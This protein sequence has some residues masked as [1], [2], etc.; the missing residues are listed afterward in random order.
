MPNWCEGVLKL[1]GKVKD[2]K[3]FAL[4]GLERYWYKSFE[5]GNVKIDLDAEIDE[6]G[7]IFIE[8]RTKV[9]NDTHSWVYFKDSKRMF[10][11]K[12]LEW[13]FQ[14]EDEEKV[15]YVCLDIKQAWDIEA[16][17]LLKISKE[18]NLDLK[19]TAFECGM[20]FTRNVE[21]VDGQVIVDEEKK[22]KNCDEYFWEVYDPRLG[23]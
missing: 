16:D 11:N 19:I 17:D 18:Y 4:N 10:L 6:Y 15:E 21:I 5:E 2:L 9:E 7:G 3:K 8:K 12:N 23:G 1:R 13:H 20:I 14:E 22:Y